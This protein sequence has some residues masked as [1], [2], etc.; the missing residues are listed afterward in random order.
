MKRLGPKFGLNSSVTTKSVGIRRT[1]IF[2]Q[3]KN[4]TKKYKN[5]HETTIDNI[6]LAID[7][8]EI[9]SLLG[10]SGCGKT[11]LLRIIA[12]FEKPDSGRIIIDGED[13]TD[14]PAYRR[15]VNM[16]FQNYALFPHMSVANNIAFGLRQEK[17]PE[18]EINK[19]VKEALEMVGLEQLAKRYPHQISGGQ[20]QRTSL[21]RSIVKRPK[22]LLLD[23]PLGSLDR[24]TREKTQMELIKIQ[25]F[26]NIT[27]IIVTHDQDEAMSL[28][29][30]VAVMND[31]GIDQIG[32]PEQIYE[33]PNSKFVANFVG[34]INL[35]AGK[36][37]A[38]ENLSVVLEIDELGMDFNI[39]C[40]EVYKLKQKLWFAI[41]PEELIMQSNKPKSNKNIINGT[42][43]D[44]A[45]MGSELFYY[46]QLKNE[47]IVKV[48]VPTSAGSKNTSLLLGSN[49]YLRWHD[50]DGVVLS[51]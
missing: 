29:D 51:K 8:A 34:S 14:L 36:V 21:A 2:V 45:F 22:L 37:K 42:I 3:I 12:G 43:I 24:N 31:G 33:Y 40:E 47:Q 23:E 10:P 13:I 19:R 11:T 25:N 48:S 44:I 15:P 5:N 1:K 18:S 46:V 28:S 4:I 17:L 32:R 50:N 6:S 49:V 35:F 26:L 9:F 7:E 16:M 38:M 20:Q 30:R 27:F 41:R 39:A